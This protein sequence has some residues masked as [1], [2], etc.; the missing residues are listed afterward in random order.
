M[1]KVA[2]AFGS[3]STNLLRDTTAAAGWLLFVTI[4]AAI[5]EGL[6]IVSR[7]LNFGFINKFGTIVHIVVSVHILIQIG[8]SVYNVSTFL[9]TP[10]L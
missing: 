6:I 7:F 1:S 10:V 2:L 4:V 3:L 9:K 5:V 8:A